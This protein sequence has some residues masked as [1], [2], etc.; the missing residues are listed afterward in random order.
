MAI[1][2]KKIVTISGESGLFKALTTTQQ[3]IVVEGLDEHKKRSV[4]QIQRYSI[5]TLDDIGIYTTGEE[6][7]IPLATVFWRLYAEFGEMVG[8]EL[9]DTAE[10]RKALMKRIVPDYDKDRVYESNIKKIIRWYNTLVEYA[11]D[12]FKEAPSNSSEASQ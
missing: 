12:L 9:H 10:K 5:S 7:S 1:D 8:T 6:D 4:R 11:P 3:A 2:I